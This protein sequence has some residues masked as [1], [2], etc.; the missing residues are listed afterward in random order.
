LPVDRALPQPLPGRAGRGS[1]SHPPLLRHRPQRERIAMDFVEAVEAPE[2]AMAGAHVGGT[3]PGR[4]TSCGAQPRDPFRRLP[5]GTRDQS[6][7]PSQNRRV[8]PGRD[9]VVGRVRQNRLEIGFAFDRIA[10]F[11]PFRWGQRQVSSS[12]VLSTSTN[13]TRQRCGEQL[14]GA[15][16]DGPH[17][18]AAGAAAWPTM[19]FSPV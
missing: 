2:A 13:G 19:R 17:Q 10:P 8:I 12:M 15:V 18:H 7:R 9:I 14:A 5:I 16:G 6:G 4:L 1:R 3:I 11:R